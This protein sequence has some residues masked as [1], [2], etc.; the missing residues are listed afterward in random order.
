MLHSL[1]LLLL[2]CFYRVTP[3]C[4]VSSE[5]MEG[6]VHEGGGGAVVGWGGGGVAVGASGPHA[7][8]TEILRLLFLQG[9]P[10]WTR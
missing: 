3:T 6:F 9:E 10:P 5:R 4:L 2:L 7:L 1:S 8:R